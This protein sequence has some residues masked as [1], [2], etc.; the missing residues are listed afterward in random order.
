[1]S[2]FIGRRV[3]TY[4]PVKYDHFVF[5]FWALMGKDSTR[6]QSVRQEAGK[7]HSCR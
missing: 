2:A 4:A 1:M 7:R 5:F 3:V 6:E